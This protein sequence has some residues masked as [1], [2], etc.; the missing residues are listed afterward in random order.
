MDGI[1]YFHEP[2]RQTVVLNHKL[3]ELTRIDAPD[4]LIGIPLLSK[5]RRNLY[6]CTADAL[7]VLNIETGISRILKETAYPVQSLTGLL[8]ADSVLQLSVADSNGSRQTLFLSAE[9]GQLLHARE[10]N[11]SLKTSGDN[12]FLHTP[13]T[14]LT[15]VLFGRAEKDTYILKPEHYGG[16]C[17]YLADSGSAVNMYTSHDNTVID[18]YDLQTGT[19]YAWLTVPGR[20]SVRCM[21]QTPDGA[22]WF[23]AEKDLSLYRWQPPA[24]SIRDDVIYTEPYHTQAEPDHNGLS[25]CS[26]YAHTLSEKHGIQIS[27]YKDAV[28][29]Q[30]ENYQLAYEYQP[31]VLQ[32]ELERID[33]HLSRFPEGFLETL[34]EK[35]TSLTISL[36]RSIVGSPESGNPEN[37][38]GI[39]FFHDFNAHIVLSTQHDTEHALYHALSHLMETVVLTESTAYDRWENLNPDTFRYDNDY[40][41]NRDRDGSLW[42]KPENEFFIDVYSMSYAKEDRARLFEYAM[43]PGHEE[44]FRSPNLQ[45]KLRQLCTGIREGFGLK[46]VREPLPWEQYL[47]P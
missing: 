16:S 14:G 23:T 9:N 45:A 40:S 25:A 30:P 26:Q 8:L 44:L 13:N 17:F 36:V 34:S 35:F 47:L 22:I 33:R 20:Q 31:T 27:V 6:Y 11:I 15:A 43:T 19:R 2:D 1:S 3:G 12:F 28:A 41:A 39:H 10:G 24:T 7:R 4:G 37:V 21:E 29:L 46:T 38:A 32:Y 5:D 42:L 18:A